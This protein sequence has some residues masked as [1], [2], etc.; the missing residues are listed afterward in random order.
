MNNTEHYPFDLPLRTEWNQRLDCEIPGKYGSN[1]LTNGVFNCSLL[2]TC[3]LTCT[4]PDQVAIRA[5]TWDSGCQS[6]Y[7]VH[8]GL[9]RFAL[10]LL[11]YVCINISRVLI[12]TALIRLCWR[13]LSQKGFEYIGSC[14]RLG[15]MTPQTQEHLKKKTDEVIRRFE[16]ISFILLFI[17]VLMHI[18]YIVI[19]STYGNTFAKSHN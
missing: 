15:E 14:N 12:M 11:V 9:F 1:G 16:A 19:L 5:A 4:G 3:N 18:P 6:E 10:S 17:A 7:M 8:A 2:P 13:A